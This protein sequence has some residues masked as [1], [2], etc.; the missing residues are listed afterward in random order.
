MAVTAKPQTTSALSA[1]KTNIAKVAITSAAPPFH[2][3]SPPESAFTITA[4]QPSRPPRALK[5]GDTFVVL[6]SRGNIGGASGGL[7]HRDTRHLS[8]LEL[9][10]NDGPPLLLGSNVRDDNSAFFVD[11]T[12]PDLMDGQRIV[13]EKDRVHILRTIFLW[14]D[15]AYQRLGVRNYGDQA[16]DLRLAIH[17]ESDFADLFEVRGARRDRRGIATAKLDG[18]DR[19]FLNYSGLDGKTRRTA[20]HFDPPPDELTTS[21]ATY[22][23]DLKPGEMRPLFIAVSCDR[24]DAPPLPFLRGLIAARREMRESTRARTS[25]QTSNERFNAVLCRSAADLAMLMTDTPQGRY[26]YAGIPWYSTTFG[27]DGLITALQMLWWSPEVAR[28]VLRRLAAYQ[29]TTTDPLADAQPGKILHE[30]RSGEM[31]ALREVPF[32][33]YYGSVDATPLFVLLAG[34]YLERT[35][36]TQTIVELW[37]NIEAALA[38]IDGPGDP[39]GDGFV[40]YKR[41]SEQGLANQGWK[42]S[43][44]AIFHADGRL[45]EGEIALVEVQGYVYAAKRMAARCARRLKREAAAQ[46]LDDEASRLAERFEAAFWCPELETYA[47]ALDGAKAPCRVRTSNAGQVLFT[48]IAAADRARSVAKE[49]LQ[50]RFFSGWGIRTVAKDEVRFNP[51][52][53]HNGSIWPHDNAL[54]ALGLARYQ[55]KPAVDT[56]LGGL[57][58]AATYMD[59]SRLPELFCGFQRQRGHGPT[60]YPVACSPQAWASATPFTLLE[61]SLGLEFDPFNG[62]IRLRN[63]RLPQFLD[64]VTLRDLQ[65]SSS[66]V[67]LRVRR[68]GDTVSLDTTRISGDIRVSIVFSS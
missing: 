10:V 21:S 37:P 17:F 41:A 66:S 7:F 27:R 31:A 44:D 2:G 8:R 32:G 57:F 46:R 18:D 12:N 22:E 52:S 19:V 28:G 42:D 40:E 58:N 49:L 59:Q 13:M 38:W 33:L 39:D 26:P 60:L 64:E 29:A 11:L 67:D 54:I 4:T 51:M 15:T 35:G 3:E 63:P 1:V 48:G 68:H 50:P 16:I 6:D 5:Y 30:M 20:L 23:L 9:R 45:A 34:L 43:Y 62:E 55:C 56:L 14:R 25:V 53:Y 65:L 61:A 36:D 47:L 24:T